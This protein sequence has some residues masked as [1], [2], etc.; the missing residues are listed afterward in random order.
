MNHGVKTIFIVI[1]MTATIIT[2]NPRAIHSRG[3]REEFDYFFVESTYLPRVK[4]NEPPQPLKDIKNQVTN[5]RAGLSL[6]LSMEGGRFIMVNEFSMGVLHF[7]Y[8]NPPPAEEDFFPDNVYN[9]G[10]SLKFR[11][12][13]KER[14][15]IAAEA[16][17]VL[18]S[19][20]KE[21]DEN[22]YHMEGGL[23]VRMDYRGWLTA[24]LGAVYTYCLG[25]P[26]VLPALDLNYLWYDRFEVKL[27]IP[28]SGEL[29]YRPNDAFDL[30][31]RAELLGN[32]YA[33]G[34]DKAF[35]TG[36]STRGTKLRYSILTVGPAVHARFAERFY[37][38]VDAGVAFQRRFRVDDEDDH[39]IV[40]LDLKSD[41]YGR[42]GFHIRM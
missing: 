1:I 40:S 21:V 7:A 20:L 24:G 26:M 38:S 4:L 18:A 2:A 14:F 17:P 35:V 30:G 16:G 10:Y 27:N 31:V 12:Y 13:F 34:S 23:V 8:E 36:R 19:D 22:H 42:I 9:F 37:I 11:G 3:A 28:H 6:P 39:E 41:L 33:I 32:R 15:W 29:W 5:L 25:E